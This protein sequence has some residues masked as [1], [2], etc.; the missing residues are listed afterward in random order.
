VNRKIIF[1]IL[2]LVLTKNNFMVMGC[3]I[4]MLGGAMESG[5]KS[6]RLPVAT[7]L[8]MVILFSSLFAF[9]GGGGHVALGQYANPMIGILPP[10]GF[11]FTEYLSFKDLINN[12]LCC[13]R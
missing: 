8:A 1:T 13:Q 3:Y 6:L 5:R 12:S 9:A 7:S 2:F 11:Y 10:P 4:L